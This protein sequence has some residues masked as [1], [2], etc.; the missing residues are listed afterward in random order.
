MTDSEY[1]FL[2]C[3][4]DEF[5][6]ILEENRINKDEELKQAVEQGISKVKL[7]TRQ[8][9]RKQKPWVW[10]KLLKKTSVYHILASG[11]N[12]ISIL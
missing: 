11:N 12:I 4:N 1:S 5:Y 9:A 3:T 8:Y 2:D 6:R 10:N 7:R